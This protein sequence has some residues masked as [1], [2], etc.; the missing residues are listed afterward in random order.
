MAGHFIG[1]RHETRTM[2]GGKSEG[3]EGKEGRRAGG[4]GRKG[5]VRA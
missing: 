2:G 5:T 1:P 3:R 4:E